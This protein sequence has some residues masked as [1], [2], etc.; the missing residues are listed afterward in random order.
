M[1]KIEII[2]KTKSTNLIFKHSIEDALIEIFRNNQ[3]IFIDQKILENSKVIQN[4]AANK[5]K[6]V[7]IIDS[8]EENKTLSQAEKAYNFLSS[9]NANR[10]HEIVAIGG[11]AVTDFA[12]F[13]AATYKRGLN[14]CLVPTSL[15]AQVDAS[16]GGK[17]AI[18]FA[19]IKNLVGSFYIP[20][21]VL[22]CSEFL[23]TLDQQEYLNGLTEVIKHAIITSIDEVNFISDNFE[24]INKRD[25]NLLNSIVE[26]SINIKANII[27]NDFE[28]T[29]QRK[30]LNFGHTFGHGIESSNM[31]N[32][33]LHGHAVA[34]GMM[35]AL[36]YSKQ[37]ELLSDEQADIALGLIKSFNY[38]FSNIKLNADEIFQFMKSDKKNKNSKI[39][40]ILLKA[41]GEPVVYEENDPDGLRYFIGDFI[42]RFKR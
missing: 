26:R 15:L 3:S 41:F 22:I 32:P 37:K 6:E 4:F 12:G 23:E 9:I 34:I 17:T 14:L 24:K 31:E 25:L 20:N 2:S 35:M 38:D 40:L 16:I 8:P 39:N 21:R 27:I 42:E 29:A 18:N 28:E 11:G 1:K 13:I 36:D 5:T 10:D 7:F 19:K 33:I 30:Y